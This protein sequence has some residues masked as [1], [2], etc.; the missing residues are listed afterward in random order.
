MISRWARGQVS[1]PTQVASG[2][3][4]D[5]AAI[6]GL[7]LTMEIDDNFANVD[8]NVAASFSANP[9]SIS[10]G[11]SVDNAVDQSQIIQA[12]YAGTTVI[13]FSGSFS[14][15]VGP[16]THRYRLFATA[17]NAVTVTY[18]ARDRSMRVSGLLGTA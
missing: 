3:G 17:A 6:D 9:G 16:G 11:V 18:T 4:T 2:A 5:F 12:S 8:F 15:P 13:Q 7:D 10:F 1:A 14:L